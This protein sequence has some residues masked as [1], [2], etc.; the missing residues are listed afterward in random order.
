M[1]R[2]PARITYDAFAP[3]YNEF[4]HLNDY[5][6]WLGEV[7]LP[8]LEK[9]GLKRGRALDVGCGTGRA[10]QPLLRRGW[11]VRACDLSPGML[12]RAREEGGEQVQLDVVDMRELPTY[13]EFELVLSLNDAVNYLLSEDDLE[14]ALARMCANLVADGLLLFDV[15]SKGTYDSG[16]WSGGSHVVEHDGRSWTWHGLGEVEGEPSVFETR[17]EGDD[18][19]TIVHRERFRPEAEVRAAMNAAGLDCLAVLGMQEID[20][21]V[22]L[23]DPADEARDY[24]VVYIGAKADR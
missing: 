4:N 17:I 7:L 22:V 10:F 19:E 11:E 24:K 5:E 3:I 23:S 20:D 6:M 14:R 16:S 18:I 2:D 9:H 21:K 13:G 12:E 8:E 1:E 15:N